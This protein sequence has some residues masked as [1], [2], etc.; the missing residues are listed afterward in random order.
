MKITRHI[1]TSLNLAEKKINHA[2]LYE[3]AAAR[4]ELAES[5]KH[6]GI[7]MGLALAGMEMAAAL[8]SAEDEYFK[9]HEKAE[10]LHKQATAALLKIS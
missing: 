9:A 3:G 1:E 2:T 4:R 8:G 10:D 6:S 5:L 7:A